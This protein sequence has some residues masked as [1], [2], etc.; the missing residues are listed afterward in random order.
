[1][2]ADPDL[3]GR[4]LATDPDCQVSALGRL[5]SALLQSV[6]TARIFAHVHIVRCGLGI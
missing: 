5:F 2:A 3:D 1:M 6:T 4:A